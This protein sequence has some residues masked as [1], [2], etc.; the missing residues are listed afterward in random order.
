[1]T[2]AV[3]FPLSLY[4]D[5]A[6][7][8]LT[9]CREGNP[10]LAY[11]ISTAHNGPNQCQ[12][13]NGTPRGRHRV[14]ACIGGGCPPG[15]VF[16]GRRPTGELWSRELAAQHPKRDWILTRILW[17]CGEEPGFNRGAEV[18]SMRRFIYIHGTPDTEPMGEPLSHGCIRMRDP[19]VAQL[20]D[21]IV[22]GTPVTID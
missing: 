2:T 11:R 20:F 12:G 5:I 4:V 17:L 9:V 13:S 6:R 8:V 18:D 3:S 10:W 7:Q 16:I 21:W 14:R 19:D 1:M 15:T 22:P